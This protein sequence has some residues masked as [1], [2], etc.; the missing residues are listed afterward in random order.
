M[1]GEHNNQYSV[2]SRSAQ[3]SRLCRA[4]VT[5]DF[6]ALRCIAL[7]CSAVQCSAVQCSAV[8]CSAV[9]CSAV[10]CIARSS[11]IAH[12][13][14]VN[15]QRMTGHV[16]TT[17]IRIASAHHIRRLQLLLHCCA[18]SAARSKSGCALHHTARAVEC[19]PSCGGC[20][21][22]SRMQRYCQP[23]LRTL[24]TTRTYGGRTKVSCERFRCTEQM[25]GTLLRCSTYY[26]TAEPSTSEPST[27]RTTALQYYSTTVLQ[28]CAR[29]Q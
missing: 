27:A 6:I 2:L 15:A 10:Q 21:W 8:Q 13:P 20:A 1:A 14:P 26:S 12:T 18:P 3:A 17:F 25:N 11:V 19:A 5:S 7:Q 9:Q 4:K 29:V 23:M 16:F 24:S 28:S 22:R